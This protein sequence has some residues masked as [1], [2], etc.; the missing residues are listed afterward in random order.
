MH[1]HPHARIHTCMRTHAHTHARTHTHL[2]ARMHAHMRVCVHARIC[3][4]A[5]AHTHTRTLARSQALL[6]RLLSRVIFEACD[7]L[8]VES[9]SACVLGFVIGR[10][11]EFNALVQAMPTHMPCGYHW[12][13]LNQMPLLVV[14]SHTAPYCAAPYS[15][16]H[17]S[18]HMLHETTRH[19]QL[20]V[21]AG[22]GR[23]GR[24]AA[25]RPT[26]CS[27]RGTWQ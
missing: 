25:P 22:G 15:T 18:R 6:R 21:C 26:R 17:T 2:H 9:A 27:I 11:A 10:S 1:T 14:C 13:S 24:C 8:V 16:C 3:V 19:K 23:E 12:L 7:S 4:H 5:P 20:A